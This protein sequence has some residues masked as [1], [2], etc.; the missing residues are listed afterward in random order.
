MSIII[1]LES[2]YRKWMTRKVYE[3]INMWLSA[4]RSFEI[5]VDAVRKEYMYAFA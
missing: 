4:D 1:I 5:N 2:L 3:H